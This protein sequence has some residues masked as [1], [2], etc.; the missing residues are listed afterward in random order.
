M[1]RRLFPLLA[2][3]LVGVS[4]LTA[5]VQAGAAPTVPV[6]G[7]DDTGLTSQSTPTGCTT[8]VEWVQEGNHYY[9]GRGKVQCTAGRYRIKLVCRNLQTGVG[10]VTYGTTVVTAPNTATT[11]CNTGNTAES[12]HAVQDP[13]GTGLTGCVTWREWVH[14]GSSHYYGRGYVQCDTGRYKAKLVCRNEQTGVGYVRYG[15]TVVTAPGSATAQCDSGNTA[16]SVQAVQDPP[17]TG[18]NGCVTWM[19]W[20]HE[21]FNTMYYGRGLVQCDTGRYGVQ[22]SCRNI[23]TGQTYVVTGYAVTAPSTNS[24]TCY[25]G[26]RVESVQAVP[27]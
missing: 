14:E 3:I 16:E 15:G 8:S 20:V 11:T 6:A 5:P 25:S 24:T 23:Q 21:S 2:A 7:T 22:L 12:V 1:P 13:P 10:Y 9:Y 27:Q 4:V 26:N 17:A 19:E 18:V